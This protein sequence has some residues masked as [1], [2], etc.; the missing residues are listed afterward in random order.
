VVRRFVTIGDPTPAG[1]QPVDPSLLPAI[2]GVVT[3]ATRWSGFDRQALS[4][5]TS[6]F[7]AEWLSPGSHRVSYYAQASFPGD[8]MALPATVTSMYS[9]GVFGTT[10]PARIRVRQAD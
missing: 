5:V 4:D 1:L 8:F 9:E 6:R 2:P 10:A 3:G 7:Y